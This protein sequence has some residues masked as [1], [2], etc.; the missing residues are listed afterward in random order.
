MQK[1]LEKMLNEEKAWE[2]LPDELLGWASKG[3]EFDEGAGDYMSLDE[4]CQMHPP[5]LPRYRNRDGQTFCNIYVSDMCHLWGCPIPHRVGKVELTANLTSKAL[6]RGD[7]KGWKEVSSHQ[8]GILATHF[9]T[10]VVAHAVG[11]HHGHIALVS[12]EPDKRGI[13]VHQAGSVC[14]L[15]LPLKQAFGSMYV[16]FHAYMPDQ[17]P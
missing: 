8:A 9:G 12:G 1:V 3:R 2:D 17:T 13:L 6:Q 4:L 5:T 10:P 11:D 15:N 16:K 14:A 7:M